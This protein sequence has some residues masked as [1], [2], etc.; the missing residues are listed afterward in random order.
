M[1]KQDLINIFEKEF[2]IIKEKFSIID[3]S[4]LDAGDS[5]IKNIW[6]PGVYVFL[7]PQRGVIRVG[8][9]FD[10]ARKRALQ[11]ISANTGGV[12]AGLVSDSEARLVLF[13]VINPEDYFWVAA[14]EVY[15]ENALSPEVP[16]GRQG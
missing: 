15:L 4:V 6:H 13:S 16:A 2:A 9:S 7:H 3:V 1:K 8:R 11:H 10:N 12:M 5:N 14:L